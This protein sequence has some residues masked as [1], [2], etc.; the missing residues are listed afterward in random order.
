MSNPNEAPQPQQPGAQPPQPGNVPPAG[1]QPPQGYPSYQ[2]P[3]AYQQPAAGYQQGLPAYGEATLG[4]NNAPP[5][6]LGYAA[7][8]RNTFGLN[9]N[10]IAQRFRD[11]TGVPQQLTISYWLWVAAAALGIVLGIVNVAVIGSQLGAIFVGAAITGLIIGII[12]SAFYIFC[13]IRLK[14]GARWARIVL[15]VLGALALIGLFA[16]LATG[17]LSF[18]GSAVAVA[19]TVLMWLPESRKHFV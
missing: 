3:P 17:N 13:A 14:E 16:Q 7:P 12:F 5:A 10:N 11:T 6:G 9:F 2:A 8:A 4:A 19:A 18:I 15:T 1:Y